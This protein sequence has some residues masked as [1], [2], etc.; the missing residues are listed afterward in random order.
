MTSKKSSLRPRPKYVA[1]CHEVHNDSQS[2]GSRVFSRLWRR[3]RYWW[4]S[5][6]SSAKSWG[7]LHVRGSAQR[8]REGLGS[9]IVVDPM[10]VDIVFQA[11][12]SDDEDRV[13]SV[14]H[15]QDHKGYHVSP[16]TTSPPVMTMLLCGRFS[17]S[18]A[19]V[20]GSFLRSLCHGPAL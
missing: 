17:F 11:E 16:V 7:H 13:Y 8:V 4:L 3:S 15:G 19:T 14:F 12:A 9:R 1:T 20:V 5:S 2:R 10:Y 18:F 6:C